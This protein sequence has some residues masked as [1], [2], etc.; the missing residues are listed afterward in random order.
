MDGECAKK[1]LVGVGIEEFVF[2]WRQSDSRS[3]RIICDTERS[4]PGSSAGVDEFFARLVFYFCR[5][6]LSPLQPL[7]WGICRQ[8]VWGMNTHSSLSLARSDSN[9]KNFHSF[10]SFPNSE[11]L[12]FFTSSVLALR[13]IPPGERKAILHFAF[14]SMLNVQQITLSENTT[15]SMWVVARLFS[16]IERKRRSRSSSR[17][18]KFIYF[19]PSS[20]FFLVLRPSSLLLSVLPYYR[21]RSRVH[22]TKSPFALSSPFSNFTRRRRRRHDVPHTTIALS[23]IIHGWWKKEEKENTQWASSRER[24]KRAGDGKTEKRTI[25]GIFERENCTRWYDTVFRLRKKERRNRKI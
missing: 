11:F 12:K 18:C 22:Y 9:R 23:T 15:F 5:R 1:I 4:E 2:H 25:K 20:F 19:P 3:R 17:E 7:L 21:R 6:H 14:D 13:P 8:K 16:N 24:E 10:Q